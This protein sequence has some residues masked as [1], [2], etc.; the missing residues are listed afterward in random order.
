YLSPQCDSTPD[1]RRRE[2]VQ[3][4]AGTDS[5]ADDGQPDEEAGRVRRTPLMPPAASLQPRDPAGRGARVHHRPVHERGL[6]T[7]HTED[8]C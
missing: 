3:D 6:R 8:E 5:G 2:L 7:A 4:G 1:S